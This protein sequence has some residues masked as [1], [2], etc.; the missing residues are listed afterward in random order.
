[1]KLLKLFLFYSII[2][3]LLSYCRKSPVDSQIDL[4]ININE[5]LIL[6]TKYV[7]SS[8]S[9]ELCVM[10]P[11]GSNL[12]VIG[13]HGYSRARWSPDKSKIVIVGNSG[14]MRDVSLIWIMDMNGQLHN[15]LTW[16]GTNPLWFHNEDRI[17]YQETIFGST[18]RVY[19]INID[20]TDEK[21]I[22]QADGST[23]LD[24]YDISASGGY[25]LGKEK[26]YYTNDE[27]KLSNTDG[28]IVKINLETGEK[29]YLTDNEL[30]DGCPRYNKDETM[31]AYLSIDMPEEVKIKNIT[32]VYVMSSDGSNKRR[33]TN[34]TIP[35]EIWPFMAWSPD[36]KKIAYGKY[37]N[38]FIVDIISGNVYNLT[39]TAKDSIRNI[40]MDWK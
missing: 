35:N 9:N 7:Y 13:R 21:L 34:E 26:F 36:G 31:I 8:S 19:S 17:L 1:M 28:E 27:G 2:I 37:N 22:Y 39:N 32:N 25:L 30:N 10:R 12:Q 38:I 16:S 33:V 18:G 29:V 24:I 40:V 4:N 14:T 5:E 15:C 6:F 11:D 20:G 3:L 23:S